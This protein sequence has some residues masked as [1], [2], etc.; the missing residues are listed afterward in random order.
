MFRSFKDSL[1]HVV[2]LFHLGKFGSDDS[3]YHILVWRQLF[4]WLEA[5]CSRGVILEVVS[6]D[7]FQKG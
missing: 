5:T 6:L 3:K 7:L 4:E 2:Q 1:L